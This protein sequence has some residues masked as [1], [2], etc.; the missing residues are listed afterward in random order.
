MIYILY[1]TYLILIQAQN[2]QA[3]ISVKSLNPLNLIPI[4]HQYPQI[5]MLISPFNLFYLIPRVVCVL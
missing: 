5:F 4:K 2:S 3:E 1:L